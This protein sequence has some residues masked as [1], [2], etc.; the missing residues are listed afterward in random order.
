MERSKFQVIETDGGGGGGGGSGGS[1]PEGSLQGSG[2]GDSRRD[3][4]M[5]RDDSK[6]GD[7]WNSAD[8]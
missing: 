3:R 2:E 5:R 6:T 1:H 8:P 7:R 4:S